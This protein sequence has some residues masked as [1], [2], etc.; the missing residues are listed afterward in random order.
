MAGRRVSA[1]PHD[2]HMRRTKDPVVS[3]LMARV[4]GQRCGD[5]GEGRCRRVVGQGEDGTWYYPGEDA[6]E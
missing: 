6:N 2:A 1:Q 5:S 4:H 3:Q